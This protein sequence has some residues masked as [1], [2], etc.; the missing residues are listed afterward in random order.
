MNK[1]G[2]NINELLFFSCIFENGTL[3]LFYH[4]KNYR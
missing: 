2:K 3:L 4:F 1:R